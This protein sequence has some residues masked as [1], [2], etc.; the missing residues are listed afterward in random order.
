MSA[1]RQNRTRPFLLKWH[2]LQS[3]EEITAATMRLTESFTLIT[4]ALAGS[5]SP[6]P[7]NTMLLASGVRFGFRQTL[8]HIVGTAVGI[9]AL[10]I[11]IAAGFGVVFDVVPGA[12]LALKTVGSLYLLYLAM[13]LATS[14]T[15]DNTSISKPLNFWEAVIFQFVN[16][17]GWVF[18]IAVVAAFL[19]PRLPAIVGGLVVAGILTFVV[20]GTAAMWALGGA[21][22]SGLVARERS[23]RVANILLAILMVASVAFLWIP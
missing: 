11:A 2:Q 22:V 5:G 7:N 21:A 10:V 9:G 23:A 1:A 18:A 6:G 20:A 16:P 15:I 17:K 4:F 3:D 14:R 12:Q 19:P 8:P 13:R